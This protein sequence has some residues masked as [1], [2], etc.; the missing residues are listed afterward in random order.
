MTITAVDNGGTANGG[1]DTSGPQF[2]DINITPVNDPPSFLKGANQTVLEDAGAQ[3]VGGWAT[4]ISR[5]PPDEALQTLTFNI[6]S[7]TNP[8]LFSAGPAV[9]SNGTLTYTTAADANGSAT[10]GVDLQD[11]GG[12]AN[13]GDD[14]SGIQTFTITVTPVND[15]PSFVAGADQTVLEDAAAQSS[16]G[17]ASGF[18]PG[19]ANESARR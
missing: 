12:T 5:G 19:P 10:I 15:A 9:A 2:F 17:W 7:N 4:S 1:D 3:S 14:T 13:G 18:D 11:N 16:A 6:T 8:T